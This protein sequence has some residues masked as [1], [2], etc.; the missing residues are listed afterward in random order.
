ML[1]DLQPTW[2]LKPEL[3]VLCSIDVSFWGKVHVF[4]AY[5]SLQF[6]FNFLYYIILDRRAYHIANK[7]VAGESCCQK[8]IV[9]NVSGQQTR[10]AVG[11]V[12]GSGP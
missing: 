3:E 2:I 4:V 8:M 5:L 12:K 11:S 9:N 1:C 6:S 10:N 7:K